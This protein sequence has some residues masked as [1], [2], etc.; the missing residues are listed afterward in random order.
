MSS[1]NQF[2]SLLAFLRL[3]ASGDCW[4]NL[5]YRSYDLDRKTGQASLNAALKALGRNSL[6]ELRDD[7]HMIMP[8]LTGND[9]LTAKV[10]RW[11]V[12]SRLV[13]R[14]IKK[15]PLR[16]KPLPE[17]KNNTDQP[18]TSPHN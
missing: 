3:E 1:I 5:T 10:C 18:Q 11:W 14:E 2:S 8:E 15:W 17:R 7:L 4:D 9:R 6:I 13:R 12:W 16:T